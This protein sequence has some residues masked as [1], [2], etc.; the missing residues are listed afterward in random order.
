M[1]QK[2]PPPSA[3]GYVLLWYGAKHTRVPLGLRP[4]ARQ[5]ILMIDHY[6]KKNRFKLSTVEWEYVRQAQAPRDFG[7][8][9]RILERSRSEQDAPAVI[10]DDITR[11]MKRLPSDDASSLVI[12][13]TPWLERIHDARL[14]RSLDQVEIS[15]WQYLFSLLNRDERNLAVARRMSRPRGSVSPKQMQRAQERAI[16]ERKRR[17]DES[18]RMVAELRDEL[19]AENPDTKLTFAA[20]ARAANER[21]L[22]TSRGSEWTSVQVS[23]ALQRLE[24]QRSD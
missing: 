12:E 5:Q 6:A 10:V 13:L 4:G 9:F 8:L 2:H 7:V 16:K 21:G 19:L 17:A 23:R 11:L 14:G 18:A 15:H 20:I 1:N 22:R 24:K 3:V